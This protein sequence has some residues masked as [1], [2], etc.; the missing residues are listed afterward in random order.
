MPIDEYFDS[1]QPLSTKFCRRLITMEKVIPFDPEKHTNLLAMTYNFDEEPAHANLPM[2]IL[3]DP[4]RRDSP[5]IFPHLQ[6]TQLSKKHKAD[7][8]LEN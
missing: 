2:K 6:T 4:S 3:K 1:E 7:A 8:P 5:L